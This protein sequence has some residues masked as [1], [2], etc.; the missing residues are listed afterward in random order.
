MALAALAV[1]GFDGASGASGRRMAGA[2]LVAFGAVLGSVGG[3][4]RR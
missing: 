1:D 3:S 4:G 2:V